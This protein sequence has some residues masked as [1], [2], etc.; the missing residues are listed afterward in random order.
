M[1]IFLLALVLPGEGFILALKELLE[2]QHLTLAFYVAY[3]FSAFLQVNTF[4]DCIQFKIVFHYAMNTLSIHF[5]YI[6][7]STLYIVVWT[8]CT[9]YTVHLTVSTRCVRFIVSFI[10]RL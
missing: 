10:F 8:Q 5:T 6:C 2:P 7:L 9:V 3:F 1:S 4:D